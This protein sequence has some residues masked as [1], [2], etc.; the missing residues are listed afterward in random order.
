MRPSTTASVVAVGFAILARA[1]GSVTDGGAIAGVLIAFILMVASGFPGFAPLLAL[2]LLTV[3]STRWGYR[4]KQRLGVAERKRGRTASQVIANLGVAAAC[5]LP[6]VWF[7]EIGDLCLVASAAALAE[8]VFR[9][10]PGVHI[11]A[12]SR[13]AIPV[14]LAG[15]PAARCGSAPTIIP[16]AVTAAT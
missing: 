7:P 13:E 10:A 8:E 12:T 15:R 16:T 5:A 4:K 11:I 6:A 3:I 2:F 9:G 14:S 1:M